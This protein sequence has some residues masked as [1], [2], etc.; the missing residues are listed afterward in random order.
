MSYIHIHKA[1][2]YRHSNKVDKNTKLKVNLHV[3]PTRFVFDI[4]P[5]RYYIY[6]KILVTNSRSVK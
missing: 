2:K 3:S 4:G 5:E 6:L 1:I